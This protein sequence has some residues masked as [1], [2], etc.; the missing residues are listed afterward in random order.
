MR[1]SNVVRTAVAVGIFALGGCA[2]AS[3]ES[4]ALAP[5]ELPRPETS[6]LKGIWRGSFSQVGAGDT[7][8]VQGQMVFQVGDDGKYSATWTTQVVA[9]SSRGSKLDT[10]GTVAANGAG[11]TFVETSGYTFT[12]KRSGDKL[13]GMRR[14]PANG[15]TI[16]VQLEKT[17]EAN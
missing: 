11:V 4:A 6:A 7:G 9:G 16:A 12:L 2:T 3:H 8:Q 13:Y 17:P 10:A 1:L 14:D 5:S 15:R